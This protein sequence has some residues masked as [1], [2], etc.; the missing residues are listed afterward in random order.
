MGNVNDRFQDVLFSA[1]DHKFESRPTPAAYVTGV[2][3]K[4]DWEPRAQ[5]V[6][7]HAYN[8]RDDKDIMLEGHVTHWQDDTTLL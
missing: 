2:G 3:R 8:R 4:Q 6:A 5:T 1:S 7:T